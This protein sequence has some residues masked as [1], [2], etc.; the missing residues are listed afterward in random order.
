[1]PTKHWLIST[2]P[3]VYLRPPAVRVGGEKSHGRHLYLA[4][5]I[6]RRVR[7]QIRSPVPFHLLYSEMRNITANSTAAYFTYIGE[8][9]SS[10]RDPGRRIGKEG[11]SM[12]LRIQ[13][14]D[15]YLFGNFLLTGSGLSVDMFSS[16][17]VVTINVQLSNSSYIG[18]APVG[19]KESLICTI[20]SLDANQ[21][22]NLTLS[23]ASLGEDLPGLN[24]SRI[25]WMNPNLSDHLEQSNING[26]SASFNSTS[27]DLNDQ[28]GSSC[29]SSVNSNIQFNFEGASV[30]VKGMAKSQNL[31]ASYRVFVDNTPILT[32]EDSDRWNAY[33]SQNQVIDLYR[34]DSL[35]IGEH[36]ILFSEIQ[37]GGQFCVL[38]ANVSRPAPAP[39]DVPS[40]SV[41]SPSLPP[42]KPLSG[43]RIA[44]VVIGL[45][46][47]IGIIVGGALFVHRRRMG[48]GGVVLDAKKLRYCSKCGAAITDRYCMECVLADPYVQD[49]DLRVKSQ[50]LNLP[51]NRSHPIHKAV[52]N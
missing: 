6:L 40:P 5:Q 1:M 30:V 28:D 42:L 19:N 10:T 46:F 52:N 26:N 34:N 38:H 7:A 17:Y 44:G 37:P 22:T 27:W 41:S 14:S 8:W 11:D 43:G 29:T 32:P 12:K 21:P 48:Y 31:S 36:T 33:A 15:L 9:S 24:L 39:T 45:L 23:L 49:V 18:H 51:T 13:G 20:S 2:K 4:G 25:E 50:D 16:Q 35:S 47:A 3:S